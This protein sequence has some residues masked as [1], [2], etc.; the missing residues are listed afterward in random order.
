MTLI[1][2]TGVPMLMIYAPVFVLAFVPIVLIESFVIA[3]IVKKPFARAL[4]MVTL[5]NFASTLVGV[6]LSWIALVIVEATIGSAGVNVGGVGGLVLQAPWL[7]PDERNLHWMIPAAG[8]T[9]AV[10]FFL[11][12]AWSESLVIRAAWTEAKTEPLLRKSVW[13]A[14]AISYTLLCVWWGVLLA[15]ALMR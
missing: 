4:G 7:G 10:P 13:A 14:N 11:V 12:S 6:P 8:L 1:A 3:R 9:L 15:R 2:N 5:A